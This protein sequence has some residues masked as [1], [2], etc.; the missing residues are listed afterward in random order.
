MGKDLTSKQIAILIKLLKEKGIITEAELQ[1]E[2][3]SFDQELYKK[4]GDH[5]ESSL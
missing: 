4:E 5:D 3:K 1:K 2:S